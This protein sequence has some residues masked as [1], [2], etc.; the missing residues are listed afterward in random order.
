MDNSGMEGGFVT[1][2]VNQ[3]FIFLLFLNKVFLFDTRVFPNVQNSRN[4]LVSDSTPV[5]FA[6]FAASA[7]RCTARFGFLPENARF[8]L[9]LRDLAAR[10]LR[11]KTDLNYLPVAASSRVLLQN[12]TEQLLDELAASTRPPLYHPLSG[13]RWQPSYT[14]ETLR[15]THH[16][17]ERFRSL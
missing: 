17:R 16:V 9:L 4:Q 3:L 11:T 14:V 8:D 13:I 10:F 5:S 12:L 15:G 7:C 1:K 6:A 2:I